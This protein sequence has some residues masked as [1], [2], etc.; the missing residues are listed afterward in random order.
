MDIRKDFPVLSKDIVY[1]DSACM[2]LKPNSV[3]NKL[4]EYYNEYPACSGRSGHQLSNR[5][6]EEVYKTRELISKFFNIKKENLIFTRNTTESINIIANNFKDKKVLITDKEHNSNLLP[7]Q[8]NCKLKVLGSNKDNTFNLEGL[9]NNIKDVDLVAINHISNLDGVI[10]PIKEVI[11]IAHENNVSVSIDA[12]QS[13]GHT[14]INFKKLDIDFLSCS[15]HKILGPTGTGLFI[16]KKE[17]LDE[18]E[19]LN[20]GGG[21]VKDSTYASHEYEEIPHKFE[22]GLQ[23]YAG[24]IALREAFNYLNKVGFSKVEKNE[25]QL[26][27]IMTEELLDKVQLIGPEDYRLRPSIFSFNV[28]GFSPLDIGMIL[29][30]SKNICIRAGAHCVHS[31][32][33]KHDLQGSARA[34]LYLYNNEDDV[35]TF[36]NEVK[37]IIK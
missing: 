12:A 17:F 37:K 22:A 1:L 23:D 10:N 18:F 35:I 20:I 33:N 31:W 8:R 34:S 5:V 30:S 24:I 19:P 6:N 3:I 4:N 25:L 32:F 21:T 13:A 9:K 29:N 26:N 2:S 14:E 11:K 15:G 36:V 28:K 7:W 16:A 27:K